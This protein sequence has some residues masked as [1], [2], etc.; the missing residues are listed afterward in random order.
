MIFQS[1]LFFSIK[2]CLLGS[3][4]YCNWHRSKRQ[5]FTANLFCAWMF[6]HL[7]MVLST[8]GEIFVLD[9]SLIPLAHDRCRCQMENTFFGWFSAICASFLSLY[10]S[11]Y[12]RV[13]V[14]IVPHLLISN[15]KSNGSFNASKIR[16]YI[17]QFIRWRIKTNHIWCWMLT[18][19]LVSLPHT[20]FSVYVSNKNM[21]VN[22]KSS[23]KQIAG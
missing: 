19:C 22:L 15:A 3:L 16:R 8:A 21:E 23:V 7:I 18:F 9:G 20:I 5:Y 1:W 4:T 17:K 14:P 12:L 10:P 2:F 6:S 13:W 11:I